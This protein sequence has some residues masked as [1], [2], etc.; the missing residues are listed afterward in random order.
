[1]SFPHDDN[2]ARWA[3]SPAATTMARLRLLLIPILAV[4]ALALAACGSSGGSRTG[5]SS[6]SGTVA[7]AGTQQ[8][9]TTTVCTIPQNNGGDHDSDNNGGPNDG[10]GCDV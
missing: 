3:R 5:P 6:P 8:G 4:A 9:S 7:P 1:M 10:D 2:R